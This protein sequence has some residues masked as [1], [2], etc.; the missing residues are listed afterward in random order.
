MWQLINI[1]KGRGKKS[2]GFSGLRK[3]ILFAHLCG[4]SVFSI[5][6]ELKAITLESYDDHFFSLA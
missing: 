6:K 3:E 4:F 2:S 5:K 1:L